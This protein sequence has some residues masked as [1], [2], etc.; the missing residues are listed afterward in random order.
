MMREAHSADAMSSSR[1]MLTSFVIAEAILLVGNLAIRIVQR[2]GEFPGWLTAALAIA[3]ALPMF[4][5]AYRFFQLLAGDL[6]E[7]LQRVVLQGMAI[8][9]AIFVPLAGLYVNA[10]VAGLI[11]FQLNPPELLLL[12]SILVGVGI[13]IASNR[14]R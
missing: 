2:A 7:M 12:P 5:F 6:D 11:S 3:T 13:L 14:F 10:Q 1:R 4:W 8:A 9:V